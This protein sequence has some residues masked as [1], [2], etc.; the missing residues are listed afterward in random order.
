M[1]P[2]ARRVLEDLAANEDCD[3]VQEGRHV[4]C[5]N[6]RTTGRVV[7][8]LLG[9]MAISILS[10]DGSRAAFTI[11]GIND[12]GRAVLRRPELEAELMKEI[13][14]KKRRPFQVVNDRI[15]HL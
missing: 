9:I 6:R 10:K 5:G 3:L 15:Q 7:N 2:G 8:E 4:Y 12:I 14:S 13:Y 1:N 11:Y